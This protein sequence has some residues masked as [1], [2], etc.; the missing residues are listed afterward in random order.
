VSLLSPYLM[1]TGPDLK[2]DEEGFCL[3]CHDAD[4]PASSDRKTN[5]SRP[6]NWST[7]PAGLN[8]LTTLNDRHDIQTSAQAGSGAKIECVNCH[9]PHTATAAQPYILDPDTTS[10]DGHVV[11]TDWYFADYQAAGDT[12]SEFCLDCHDGTFPAGV[13]DH[14]TP[15]VDLEA[16]WQGDNMGAGAAKSTNVV[17]G[18]GYN[19]KNEPTMACKDCHASHVQWDPNGN[20][21]AGNTTLFRAQPMIFQKGT[22]TPVPIS[23]GPANLV[24]SLTDNNGADPLVSGGYWCNTCHNRSSMDTKSN[25]Y[26]CHRHGDGRF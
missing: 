23:F 7:L 3:G 19:A 14:T 9:N 16:L 21:G 8:G 25:C 17:A 11:G 20:G 26:G 22:T 1:T 10:A 18:L 6:I 2:E 15:M 24:Y 4:G 12:L 5:M 13:L